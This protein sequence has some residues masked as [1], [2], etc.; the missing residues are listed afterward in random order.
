MKSRDMVC[1][2]PGTR[3]RCRKVID[4]SVTYV[5]G[6]EN[7]SGWRPRGDGLI[8]DHQKQLET[9]QKILEVNS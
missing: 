3:R 1:G 6:E 9:L 8:L 2:S 5:R 7:L 4:T